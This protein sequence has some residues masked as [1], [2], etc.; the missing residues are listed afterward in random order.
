[1]RYMK[2]EVR[3]SVLGYIQRGGSPTARSRLLAARLGS[4]A[5]RALCEGHVATLAAIQ[6]CAFVPVPLSLAVKK[7]KRIDHQ[8]YKLTYQLAL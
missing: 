4:L 5:V 7:V 1:M 3:L 6:K 8:A 2:L